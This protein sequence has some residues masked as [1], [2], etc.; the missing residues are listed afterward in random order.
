MAEL[1]K[2]KRMLVD[3][4][5][6]YR[7]TL[8]KQPG[9]SRLEAGNI[10]VVAEVMGDYENLLPVLEVAVISQPTSADAYYHMACIYARKGMDQE[11][12]EYLEKAVIANP[13]RQPFF[14]ADPDLESIKNR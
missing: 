10:T 5:K 11:A 7:N 13:E 4:V 1:S 6:H 14:D 12:A 9:F 2:R 3:A 8:A